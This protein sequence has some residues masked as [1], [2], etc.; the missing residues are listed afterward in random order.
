MNKEQM[1]EQSMER[2]MYCRELQQ[3][4]MACVEFLRK[5]DRD[6]KIGDDI[7]YTTLMRSELDEWRNLL[8]WGLTCSHE[9]IDR[10]K[11]A[12][13]ERF[14]ADRMHVAHWFQN[15]EY[16]SSWLTADEEEFREMA[17]KAFAPKDEKE[18][19]K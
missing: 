14:L 19:S 11:A 15:D 9:A 18:E 12:V 1:L 8:I 2:I 16:P 10:I 7:V 4:Y 5:K 6:F 13:H 17:K 3:N